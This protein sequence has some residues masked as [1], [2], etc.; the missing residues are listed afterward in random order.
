MM[1]SSLLSKKEK[2]Y[3]LLRAYY[4]LSWSWAFVMLFPITVLYHCTNGGL[5]KAKGFVQ[6]ALP[7][8]LKSA[9]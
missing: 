5:S 9:L 4:V 8:K 1:E 2:R 6:L 3:C 7:N